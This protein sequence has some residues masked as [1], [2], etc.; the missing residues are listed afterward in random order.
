MNDDPK[1]TAPIRRYEIIADS[2]T[3]NED[4]G[5][6]FIKQE[7]VSFDVR[8]A[9]IYEGEL[10]IPDEIQKRKIGMQVLGL[11]CRTRS[12]DIRAFGHTEENSSETVTIH[13]PKNRERVSI[14]Q[15]L[16]IASTKE[17]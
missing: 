1:L 6:A 4:L 15:L 11:T 13:V 14:L 12:G 16:D 8:L 2:E 9:G 17:E 5:L 10:P 3:V 7:P